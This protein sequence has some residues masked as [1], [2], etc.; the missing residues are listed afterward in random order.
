MYNDVAYL[1]RETYD[2]D[3]F[4][5]QIPAQ[6]LSEVFCKVKSVGMREFYAAA[7]TDIKP[8]LTV[9]IPDEWDYNG[10]TLMQIEGITEPDGITLTTFNIARTYRKGRTLEVTLE[11]RMSQNG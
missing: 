9:I 2:L 10:E 7:V 8:E 11:R 6:E 5:N 3:N 1:I 4:G